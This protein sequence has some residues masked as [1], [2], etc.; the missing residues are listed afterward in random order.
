MLGR[1]DLP[2]IFCSIIGVLLYIAA[3][4]SLLLSVVTAF[5]R[6][7]GCFP[8]RKLCQNLST[9]KATITGIVGAIVYDSALLSPIIVG[10]ISV[11][12]FMPYG[13]CL[14][15]NDNN[16][17]VLVDNIAALGA[18]GAYSCVTITAFIYLIIFIR[19]RTQSINFGVNKRAT[20][21]KATR[22]MALLFIFYV[23]CWSPDIIHNNVDVTLKAPVWVT[24]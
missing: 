24:R 22:N 11:G 6:L 14:I 10:Y 7:L 2:Y 19:L 4:A 5:N 17:N 16:M 20:Y 13:A 8:E 12:Y 18:L 15:T 9:N 23:L 1:W 3:G 21:I